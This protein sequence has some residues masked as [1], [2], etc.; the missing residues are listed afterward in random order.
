MAKTIKP[1]T[2]K[3]I[4][5]TC[6]QNYEIDFPRKYHYENISNKK[7]GEHPYFECFH[8]GIHDFVIS[9]ITFFDQDDNQLVTQLSI[10]PNNDSYDEILANT[11]VD[12]GEINE[13]FICGKCGMSGKL[14]ILPDTFLNNL[15]MLPKSKQ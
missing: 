4:F 5:D 3:G 15:G 11:L 2:P 12:D 6:D 10:N 7:L 8:C 14:T 13:E 9:R 1:K